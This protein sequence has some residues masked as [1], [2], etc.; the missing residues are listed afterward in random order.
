MPVFNVCVGLRFVIARA[1]SGGR[2]GER[3]VRLR[4][5]ACGINC[6]I[7]DSMKT[8]IDLLGDTYR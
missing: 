6:N 1:V 8:R 5:N 3:C 4:D 2:T 7:S